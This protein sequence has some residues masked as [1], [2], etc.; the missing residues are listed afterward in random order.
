[1]NVQL[2]LGTIYAFLLVLARV[3]G[4]FVFLP[5]SVFRNAPIVVR[6]ALTFLTTIALYP[7]WPHLPDVSHSVGQLA[8]W[9][10]SEMGFGLVSGLAV[11]LLNEGFQIGA[12]VLGMP[13]GFGYAQTIDPASQ[14]DSSILQVITAL[15]TGLLFFSLGLDGHLLRILAASLEKHPAGSWSIS[16]ASLE[17]VIQLGA[18]MFSL[19]VRV[20]L[21]VIALLLLLDVALALLGR[22]Q[23]QLHLLSLAFPVKMIAALGVLIAIAPLMPKL[24]SGAAMRTMN[25]LRHVAVF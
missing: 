7:A 23:Q 4:L 11:G 6:A 19:G 24:F 14:A 15:M 3:S 18:G 12:Q 8:G 5:L 17:S 25:A 16:T 9:A 2:S 10:L 21:P 22:M 13:A 20:A 1:M